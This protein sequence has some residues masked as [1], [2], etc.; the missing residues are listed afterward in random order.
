MSRLTAF[1]SGGIALAN[2]VAGMF[3][4][5]YWRR[6]RDQLL[7]MFALAFWIFALERILLMLVSPESE[8]RP[9]V[10]LVRICGFMMIVWGIWQKNRGK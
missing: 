1:L 6:S 3:F 2:W 5:Q 9:L 7:L 4:Y 10:Y 8:I